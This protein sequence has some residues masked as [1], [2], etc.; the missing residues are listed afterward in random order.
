MDSLHEK[1]ASAALRAIRC[2]QDAF[3]NDA[4]SHPSSSQAHSLTTDDVK[5]L[6]AF[7]N[8]ANAS[9]AAM[10]RVH[11]STLMDAETREALLRE[12]IRHELIDHAA[13]TAHAEQCYLQRSGEVRFSSSS[14]ATDGKNRDP[15]HSLHS[16]QESPRHE[17]DNRATTRSSLQTHHTLSV[18]HTARLARLSEA[19]W[20]HSSP[21]DDVTRTSQS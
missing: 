7:A 16:E 6:G 9:I 10:R 5:R 13:Q 17:P 11:S 20:S 19:A 15:L 14:T 3:G 4:A 8:Q 21:P 12:T 2:L 1:H 18:A